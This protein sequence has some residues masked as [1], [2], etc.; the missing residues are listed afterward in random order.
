[1]F[2]CG[3]LGLGVT[4]GMPLGVLVLLVVGVVLGLYC[5]V[6]ADTFCVL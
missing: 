5:V 4:L 2:G 6:G 1:M 3:V